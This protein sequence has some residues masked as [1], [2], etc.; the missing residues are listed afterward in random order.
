[1]SSH[2]ASSEYPDSYTVLL[3]GPTGSGKSHTLN[4]LFGQEILKIDASDDAQRGYIEETIAFFT[5]NEALPKKVS[6]TGNRALTRKT[7]LKP[8]LVDLF[9]YT[10][11]KLQVSAT[12]TAQK[13][14]IMTLKS[15]PA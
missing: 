6:Q 14:R 8:H 1:M 5:A 7:D 2:N 3:L 9:S 4:N 12:A 10:S 15:L 11:S 13:L